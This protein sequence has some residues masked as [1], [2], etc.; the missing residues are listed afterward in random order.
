MSFFSR[1]S[2][3]ARPPD[4]GSEIDGTQITLYWTW[5]RA[6]CPE[7]NGADGPPLMDLFR[8]ACLS[9]D[10]VRLG[11]L[12]GHESEWV[13]LAVAGGCGRS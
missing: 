9:S 1:R 4:I 11:A 2:R 7:S 5:L 3:R 12:S 13:R 8:D 10:S 6:G